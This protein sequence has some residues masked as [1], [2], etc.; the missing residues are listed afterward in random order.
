LVGVETLGYGEEIATSRAKVYCGAC[1]WA[2]FEVKIV[3]HCQNRKKNNTMAYAIFI[4][5]EPPRQICGLHEVSYKCRTQICRLASL[6]TRV[7]CV[8]VVV[9]CGITREFFT[10]FIFICLGRDVFGG[11]NR[12]F[13]CIP[14]KFIHRYS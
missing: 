8:V 13:C 3:S 1:V 6:V 10:L 12:M 2:Y 7:V 9:V 5:Y 14:A 4:F 11:K